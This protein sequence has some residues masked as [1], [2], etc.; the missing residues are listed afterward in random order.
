MFG[1]PL[2]YSSQ[3]CTTCNVFQHLLAA[4]PAQVWISMGEPLIH[5]ELSK[6]GFLR[7]HNFH[8]PFLCCSEDGRERMLA[9]LQAA[10][11]VLHYGVYELEIGWS[12]SPPPLNVS[13]VL[14]WSA[15]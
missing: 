2:S 8:W 15:V 10:L 9:H 3:S 7:G 6:R 14:R 4:I 13:E 5:S 1:G 11:R 12:R